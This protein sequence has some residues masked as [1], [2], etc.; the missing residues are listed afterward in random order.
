MD[1]SAQR[2][3]S[4]RQSGRPLK[5]A[6][7]RA[8]RQAFGRNPAA[9]TARD[10]PARHTGT[11]LADA[12]GV[13]TV[14]QLA[15]GYTD[16]L[17]A[18][19]G[20]GPQGRG[21]IESATGVSRP[22]IIKDLGGP[23][24]GKDLTTSPTTTTATDGKTT[25]GSRPSP[26]RSRRQP[27][28]ASRV[29]V[30][31]ATVLP[32]RWERRKVDAD[33]ADV[34]AQVDSATAGREE[35]HMF[36]VKPGES[37]LVLKISFE[38]VRDPGDSAM[39][40]VPRDRCLRAIRLATTVLTAVIRMTALSACRRGPEDPIEGRLEYGGKIAYQVI[41]LENGKKV[42]CA[43][44]AANGVSLTCDWAGAH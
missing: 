33:R 31:T 9:S 29:R 18:G 8:Y 26:N 22:T 3:P 41:V 24:G 42:D 17:G 14:N 12:A 28:H 25:S 27:E 10:S 43:V 6:A 21:S 39:R 1:G 4:H 7:Q 30:R 20:P 13:M 38:M 11:Q 5:T 44:A 15:H 37:D 16:W 2:G 35:K 19:T 23:T 40:V 32:D 36:A 34:K